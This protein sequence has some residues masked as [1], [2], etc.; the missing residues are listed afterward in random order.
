MCLNCCNVMIKF[1]HEVGASYGQAKKVVSWDEIYFW[2]RCYED[3]W[4]DNI[5]CRIL[6]KLS[7]LSSRRVW[8]DSLQFWKKW[9]KCY[10][11]ALHATET[12]R[13]E[14][15]IDVANFIVVV[16]RNCHSHPQASAIT[17]LL[18]QKPL[19]LRQ[20][21]PPAKRLQLAESSDNG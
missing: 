1:Y 7:W 10:Q 8:E 17:T 20:D 14:E 19:T 5:A 3:C 9:V 6:H 15:S 18:S 4:N 13:K 12:L 2:W 11:I 21:P 16:L